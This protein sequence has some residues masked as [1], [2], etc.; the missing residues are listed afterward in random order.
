[1]MP[2]RT[3]TVFI[4]CHPKTVYEFVSNPAN[5]PKW[6]PAFVR[7]ITLVGGVWIADTPQGPTT[8]RIAP[9]NDHGILDHWVTPAGGAEIYVPMRVLPNA[10]GSQILFT[11]FQYPGMTEEAV[12]KDAAL[13]EQDLNSLKRVLE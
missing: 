2:S 6:A 8:F 10:E 11:L 12:A 5:L 9:K 3:L 7:S 1:M 4:A 13:V